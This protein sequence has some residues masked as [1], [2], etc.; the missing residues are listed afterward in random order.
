MKIGVIGFQGD[1]EEHINILKRLHDKGEDIE[2][3]RVKNKDQL[4]E[5]SAIIIPGGESTTIY[6]LIK[7]YG[8]YEDIITWIETNNPKGITR[9]QIDNV[10]KDL[11]G[12]DTRTINKYEPIVLTTLKEKGYYE[13][14]K[15]P[16]VL[17]RYDL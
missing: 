7:E 16:R 3:I 5:V 1:V 13:H 8:I 4:R 9:E 11:K 10:I 14:P 6:K 12:F 15:N 17:I 2:P